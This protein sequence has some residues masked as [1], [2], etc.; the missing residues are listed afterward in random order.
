MDR[1]EEICSSGR[2]QKNPD[3]EAVDRMR[4]EGTPLNI[5]DLTSYLCHFHLH[6]LIFEHQDFLDGGKGSNS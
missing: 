4:K 5:E 6:Y 3:E 2:S 1:T